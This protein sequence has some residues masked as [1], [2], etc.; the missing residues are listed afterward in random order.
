MA[1]PRADGLPYGQLG[2]P[3]YNTTRNWW[4]FSRE[5]KE[6]QLL[7]PVTSVLADQG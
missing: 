3:V 7:H 1:D 5:L 4:S 6:G 2:E